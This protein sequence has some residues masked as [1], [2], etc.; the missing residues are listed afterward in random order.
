LAPLLFVASTALHAQTPPPAA[1]LPNPDALPLAPPNLRLPG[2]D[3]REC[4]PTKFSALCAAGRW[5]QFSRMTMK[6]AGP[7]FSADYVLEQA[8][9]GE[10]HATYRERVQGNERGGEIILIGT[11]G[12]AYRSR[13]KFPDAGSIIDYTTSNPL[14]MGQLVA[15]LLD[16]GVL[17]PPSEVS[18]PQP[19]KASNATQY[20][21]TAAPRMALLY[22]APWSMTGSVRRAQDDAVAFTLRL[23]YTPVDR[24]GMAIKGKSDNLTLEGV[25]S[26]APKLPAFPESFDLLGWKLMKLETPL[27]S[28]SNLGEAR[29]AVGP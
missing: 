6:V 29:E 13:E 17:G 7:R 11:D 9:N 25:V 5:L 26:Y 14:M 20:L 16:L 27:R 8:Q 19:I 4:G 23:R 12:F 21:R 10:L 22:G 28:V 2:P 24:N 15:L 3:P 18:A 1:A